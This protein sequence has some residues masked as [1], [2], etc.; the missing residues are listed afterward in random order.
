MYNRLFDSN[1]FIR[2]YYICL[3]WMDR[4]YCLYCYNL[5]NNRWQYYNDG[6]N[7]LGS[8][9]ELVDKLDLKSDNQ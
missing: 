7:I 2:I 1:L 3:I 6:L 5:L 4:C 8:M 9:L